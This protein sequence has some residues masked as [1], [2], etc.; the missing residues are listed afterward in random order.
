MS[1][2]NLGNAA[3]LVAL[4]II[5]VGGCDSRAAASSA[6]PPTRYRVDP[7]RQRVWLLTVDGVI[8][9]DAAAPAKVAVSLPEWQW[10]APPYG[11]L[12]DLAIGPNGEAVITSNV[13]PTLWRIDPGT[14]AVSVHPLALDADLDKDVGFS[15]IA[16]SPE[17]GAF[18][19]VG[20]YDG[21][22]WR[23][24]PVLASARKLAP[25]DRPAV[26]LGQRT[27]SPRTASCPQR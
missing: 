23:I 3:L 26:A 7:A 24:D 1:N 10:V 9:D 4:L 20:I 16:Y 13:L 22:L 14:L 18:F 25:R 8:V 17:H 6:D 15:R 11:C 27:V 21:A 19:A 12:P 5:P 2:A